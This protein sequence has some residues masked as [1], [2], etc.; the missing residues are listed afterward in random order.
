MTSKITN[1]DLQLVKRFSVILQ[2]LCCELKVTTAKYK[3]YCFQTAQL[4][5]K[6]YDWY[7]M[8][9]TLHKIL[10]HGAEVI[11]SLLIP[12]GQLSED[13]QEARNKDSKRFREYNTRKCGRLETNE[14]LLHKLLI[15]SDPLLAS[16]RHKWTKNEFSLDDEA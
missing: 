1:I 7:Y 12:I 13:A 3:T 15:S 6:L 10:F 14:D 16:Y 2:V 4:Y 11:E 9:A 5:V 8:P